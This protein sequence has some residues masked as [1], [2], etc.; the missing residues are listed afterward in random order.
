MYLTYLLSQKS[1]ESRMVFGP[2]RDS[3]QREDF[4]DFLDSKTT[5]CP[6]TNVRVQMCLVSSVPK[7][8]VSIR[9][10]SLPEFMALMQPY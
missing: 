6:D 2:F 9:P 8:F 10:E 5:L 1:G 4:L 3:F 7:G